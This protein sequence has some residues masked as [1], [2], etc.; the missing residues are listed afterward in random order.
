MAKLWG[1]VSGE[2]ATGRSSVV[3]TWEQQYNFREPP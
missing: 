3:G 1:I 2:G